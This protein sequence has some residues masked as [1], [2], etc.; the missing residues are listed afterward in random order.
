MENLCP[1]F[2]AL[3]N[4]VQRTL[5]QDH[6][7]DPKVSTADW[8]KHRAMAELAEERTLEAIKV[9]KQK[10]IDSEKHWFPWEITFSIERRK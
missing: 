9:H 6:N 4:D 8:L 1:T 7:F 2:D 3:C 5:K 10:L